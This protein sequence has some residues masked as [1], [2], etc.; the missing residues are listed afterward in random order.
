MGG[1]LLVSYTR[2]RAEGLGLDCQVGLMQRAERV[3]LLGLGSLL[4]GF[5]WNGKVLDVII[6]VVAV[7]T[8]L[9]AIHRIVWVYQHGRGIPL[10]RPETGLPD[11]QG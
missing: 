1:S 7:L 4:F 6:I 11:R 5:S 3:V 9:T 8:N 2:A 10:G